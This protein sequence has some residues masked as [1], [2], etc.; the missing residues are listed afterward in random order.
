MSNWWKE[1]MTPKQRA[2]AD[3]AAKKLD[4]AGVNYMIA[5]FPKDLDDIEEMGAV[6]NLPSVV[7]E[8]WTRT[9]LAAIELDAMQK[10]RSPI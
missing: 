7:V 3:S 10:V 6:T 9:G 2:A 5:V 4:R 8:A 1:N